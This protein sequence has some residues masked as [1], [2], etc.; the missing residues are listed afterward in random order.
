MTSAT[1]QLHA[2]SLDVPDETSAMGNM[3][4]FEVVHLGDTTV[5]RVT[6]QPGFHW[7]EHA[8]PIAGTELCMARH[9]GYVVSGRAMV[10]L[11]D[12][13]E[14][15]LAAGDAFDVPP[16]HDA[17]VVGDVPYVTLD[18]KIAV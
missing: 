13:T 2:K 17:W 12:G 6:Y 1:K 16:G 15:E 7:T 18:F 8:R 11:A 9:I 10:R 14:R 4:R 3:G 5:A